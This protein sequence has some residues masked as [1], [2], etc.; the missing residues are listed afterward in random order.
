MSEYDWGADAVELLNEEG[1]GLTTEQYLARLRLCLREHVTRLAAAE[2]QAKQRLEDVQD[3]TEERNRL[4]H[5][6]GLDVQLIA[7]EMREMRASERE[8]KADLAAARSENEQLNEEADRQNIHIT[9]LMCER[10]A[11]R[12]ALEP[13]RSGEWGA[14]KAWIVEG[15]PTREEGI[16][17]ARH[18]TALN[19]Q[20]DALLAP[21]RPR[22]TK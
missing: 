5:H 10:D 14:I 2:E 7:D 13:F 12:R 8:L 17:A 20:V 11:A 9:N 21:E 18:L 4:R 19:A 22:E 6:V 3:L 1:L 15:A 16:A